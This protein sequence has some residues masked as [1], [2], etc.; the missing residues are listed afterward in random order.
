MKLR[1]SM[2][3][4]L[5]NYVTTQ[6]SKLFDVELEDSICTDLEKCIVRHSKQTIE[7]QDGVAAWDNHKFTNIYKH[8]F[9]SLKHAFN[10]NEELKDQV[11]KRKVSV[12]EVVAM[13]PEQLQPG[14]VYAKTVED[15][16]HKEMKKE[17]LI[18]KAEEGVS[19]F[20]TCNKCK[21][22]KTTYYQLQT[23]SADEP[24]TT[25][26]SCLNCGKRWKC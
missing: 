25:Y 16:V 10:S 23:R 9:L 24:M 19:G 7:K 5:R 1:K 12:V 26:V 4:P 17:Y 14:G 11:L 2:D 6:L 22:N 18:R 3:N 8:K 21:S 13:R 15:N 20:L